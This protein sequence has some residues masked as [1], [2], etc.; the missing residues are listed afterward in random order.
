MASADLPQFAPVI[1]YRNG[2][3]YSALDA[4]QQYAGTPNSKALPA[5]FSFDARI[6]RDFLFRK[7]K[8]RVL[9]SMFNVT[10]HANFDAVRW[11]TA[12]PQ[13]GEVLGMRPR[14]FR[15]DFDWLF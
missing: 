9:F 6:G 15:L 7:H 1:E 12:D 8:F 11:N 3:P 14:R 2:F 13:F 5:F 4:A 10:N